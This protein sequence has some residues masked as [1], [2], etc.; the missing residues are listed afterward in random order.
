MGIFRSNKKIKTFG[1]DLTKLLDFERKHYDGADFVPKIIRDIVHLIQTRHLEEEGLFR[2][3]ASSSDLE[4]YINKIN[5][6]YK[7]DI[8][9]AD[10]HILCGLF[11]RF[12]KSLPNCLLT[13]ERYDNFILKSKMAK[14]DESDEMQIACLQKF[15]KELPQYYYD[16]AKYCFW[17]FTSVAQ[18]EAV[19]RMG[20]ANLATVFAPTF[21]F[22]DNPNAKKNRKK[23]KKHAKKTAGSPTVAC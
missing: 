11:K 8:S 14:A 13:R 17:F 18:F 1:T 19:N 12:F 15:Y 5:K 10:P 21:L 6:N 23:K 20:Y 3:A 2:K 16:T 4:D 9:K 7:Y 22:R